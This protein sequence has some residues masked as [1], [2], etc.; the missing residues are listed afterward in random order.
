MFAHQYRIHGPAGGG[1]E[2]QQIALPDLAAGLRPGLQ[3]A[4]AAHHHVAQKNQ[5]QADGAY[6]RHPVFQDQH[7]H[8]RGAQRQGAGQQHRGMGGR[9]EIKAAVGQAG[10]TDTAD[11][12]DQRGE[13]KAQRRQ[14]QP[15]RR[16][17][18][19]ATVARTPPDQPRTPGQQH[20]RRADETQ[21]ADVQRREA[22]VRRGACN[23]DEGG[24]DGDGHDGGKHTDRLGRK[25]HGSIIRASGGLAGQGR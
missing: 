10:V 11:Q 17:Q 25:T 12:A 13:P 4:G 3:Q 19:G 5:A 9:C 23:H 8:Q 2:K 22:A 1:A 7:G 14:A 21:Q 16:R 15:A 24:P 18:S 20:Q 6:P